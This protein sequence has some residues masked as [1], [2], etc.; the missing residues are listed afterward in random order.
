[1]D[2][3]SLQRQ[4]ES[5]G[6]SLK[7]TVLSDGTWLAQHR[8][9]VS[10]DKTPVDYQLDVVALPRGEVFTL[11]FR[12]GL[13][14]KLDVR[15][16]ALR[17]RQRHL[18]LL[19]ARP[20]EKHK[21]LCGHDERHWFVAGLPD[22]RP[23]RTVPDALEALKPE[24]VLAALQRGHIPAKEANR[25]HNKGFCRQGEW[26]FVPRPDFVPEHPAWIL[27]QAARGGRALPHRRRDG[28]CLQGLP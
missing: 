2:E 6:A 1:M 25:R 5:M 10:R 28:L 21:F 14:G 23:V 3:F 7:I 8:R 20:G 19:V 13:A 17:P 4:F 22:S 9:P 18:V 12:Q 24:G 15:V 27:Q 11:S 26:F 16:V